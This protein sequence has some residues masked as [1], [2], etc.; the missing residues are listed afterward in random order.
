MFERFTKNCILN[1]EF[2]KWFVR[3][4]TEGGRATRQKKPMF[5][6]IHTRTQG[7]ARSAVPQMVRLANSPHFQKTRN[8]LILKTGEVLLF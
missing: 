8:K 1:P 2:R 7:F 4:K 5:K 6:P 3:T